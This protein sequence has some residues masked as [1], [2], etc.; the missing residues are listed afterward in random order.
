MLRM[1]LPV[2]GPL[3]LLTHVNNMHCQARDG[4]P[5]LS[6]MLCI[7]CQEWH[8]VH[9]ASHT[10]PSRKERVFREYPINYYLTVDLSR[11]RAAPRARLSYLAFESDGAF[12]A[13][14]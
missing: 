4:L 1:L 13:Q 14:C 9:Q 12:P 6:A 2:F 5:P 10:M 8:D 11:F 7:V 3:Y